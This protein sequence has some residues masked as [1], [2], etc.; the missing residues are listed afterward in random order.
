MVAEVA[1]VAWE[2]A[3]KQSGRALDFWLAAERYVR[4]MTAMVARTPWWP[5]L[6][7]G[8]LT[9]MRDSSAVYFKRIRELAHLM[10]QA[11]GEQIGSPLDIW[12]AAERHILVVMAS[13]I[14]SASSAAVA[15]D[16]LARAFGTFSPVAHIDLIR[17]TAYQMW[18]LAG[19]HHGHALDDWL[20]AEEAVLNRLMRAPEPTNPPPGTTPTRPRSP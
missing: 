19:R 20:D 5:F 1:S 8:V 3:G 9:G 18:E 4:G 12:L 15:G 16:T 6:D 10:W 2:S 7:E 14:R 11:G 13:A 17:L